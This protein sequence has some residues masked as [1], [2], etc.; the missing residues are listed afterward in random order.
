[1]AAQLLGKNSK[2]TFS[3]YVGIIVSSLAVLFATWYSPKQRSIGYPVGSTFN[4]I[5][6]GVFRL[7]GLLGSNELKLGQN[8]VMFASWSTHSCPVGNSLLCTLIGPYGNGVM[9][10]DFSY[11]FYRKTATYSL[12][13][14]MHV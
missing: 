3:Y 14:Q 7:H 8:A 11:N 12:D 10:E 4:T 9:L 6:I 13:I 2:A 5:A 1:M